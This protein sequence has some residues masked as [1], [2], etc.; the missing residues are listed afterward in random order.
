MG[1]PNSCTELQ[2]ETQVCV[3]ALILKSQ[4]VPKHV[5][6]DAAI[7]LAVDIDYVHVTLRWV[8]NDGAVKDTRVGIL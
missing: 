7:D 4:T 8:A 2:N 5:G 1:I 6:V 3:H